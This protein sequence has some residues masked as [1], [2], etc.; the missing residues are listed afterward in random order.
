MRQRLIKVKRRKDID[1]IKYARVVKIAKIQKPKSLR[2]KDSLRHISK[3]L[4]ILFLVFS[5]TFSFTGIAVLSYL[6]DRNI[7]IPEAE[8][9]IGEIP[10][11]T[12]IY[13]RS[14]QTRLYRLFS[15]VSNSDEITIDQVSNTIISAFMAAEDSEFYYH[16]GFNP[17][18]ITRCVLNMLSQKSECGASTITQQLI[19][20]TTKQNQPTVERKIDEIILAIKVERKYTKDEIMEMYLNV[21]P[22]G[23][24]ITSIKTA[25]KF[26]FGIQD[27]KQ[28]SL[29]QA[30]ILA[31]I[32]NNPTK[33][34]PTLS[35]NPELAKKDLEERRIYVFNQLKEKLDRINEQLKKRKPDEAVLTQ[36]MVD[37][38]MKQEVK[39]VEPIIND[40]KAPH[41]VNYALDQLQK[42]PYNNGKPFTLDELKNG[43]YK[44]ITSLDYGLQLAAERRVASAGNQYKKWNMFNAALMTTVPSTGEILTMA[45]SKGFYS[46]SEA[47]NNQGQRCKFDPEVNVLN[48]LQSPGS[49]NKPLGY[50]KAYEESRIFPGSFLPDI[51]IKIGNYT[52]RNWDGKYMGLN[53]YAGN[54]LAQSRNIPALQVAELIRVNNYIDTAKSFGYTTYEGRDLGPS[55]ILGGVD[56]LFTE[57]V[58]AFGVFANGGNLVKLDPILKIF[59]R[60]GNTI[61]S[62][63]PVKE[64]V[65]DPAAIYQTNMS[66]FRLNSLG[67]SIAW[68]NRDIAGKTGTTENNIDSMVIMYSPDFVTFG[69]SGNNNNNPMNRF[70]GYPA[71]VTTPWVKD[72]M[73]EISGAEYFNKKTPFARPSNVYFGGGDCDSKG[74]C[75]GL[76]RGWLI[77]GREPIRGDVTYKSGSRGYRMPVPKMQTFLEQYIKK[78][79]PPPPPPTEITP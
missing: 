43:G 59:D 38:A 37:E 9:V 16:Y 67:A 35:Q 48:T 14:G 4:L 57:H 7:K 25:A 41:F 56:V 34:S 17:S 69:W 28:L 51:P 27:I 74:Q 26:Y 42:K 52:P 70:Y 39:F 40:I 60:D 8:K 68:D 53:N 3:I 24:S 73:K 49:T 77:R 64:Q 78:I 58:Q 47:C 33:L 71:Y 18:A 44:I 11:A 2:V 21:T 6:Q 20:I 31:S 62:A 79:T 13:E 61:Y 65:A 5:V 12:E 50:Y 15:D 32:V 22:Y 55:V 1:A 30:V 63:N 76:V 23:S 19:K 36:E 46:Q 54:M 75:L 45:G 29:A 10:A 66:L 72:Y